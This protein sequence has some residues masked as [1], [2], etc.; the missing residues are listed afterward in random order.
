MAGGRGLYRVAVA[1]GSAVDAARPEPVSAVAMQTL[2][3]AGKYTLITGASSGLGLEMARIVARDHKGHLVLVARRLDR[4][5][6]LATELREAHG[7]EVVCVRADMTSHDDVT[8]AFEEAT[9]GRV[10][11]AAIL[12]AGVSYF[13]R[14]LDL[15]FEDFSAMLATNVTS[16][17]WLTQRFAQH[18]LAESPGGGVMIVSSVAGTT[19]TPFQAA[20]SGT[21][22][23][24]NNFGLALGEE[25]AGE[26]VSVTVFVPG[27]I[28]TEMGQK[29]GTGKKFKKGDVGMMDPDVC[30]R[31][32]VRGMT[33]RARFVI[34]GALNTLND[35]LLRF[36]P[37]A[38][39]TAM[40]ARIYRD[41]LPA[42]SG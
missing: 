35:L 11:H 28:A 6:S 12:N 20:Y 5:E 25:L 16:V 37:R 15:G 10:I 22:A 27:G 32:A 13:G 19:A 33:R 9:R 29:S 4:L 41:A 17:V 31:Y 30:A 3:L 26:P 34:P 40:V 36:A 7:V 23:F 1:F 24:L 39:A 14:G 38:I 21:K 42:K 8:R 18:I 2:S